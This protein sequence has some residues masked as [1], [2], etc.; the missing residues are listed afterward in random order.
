MNNSEIYRYW[1]FTQISKIVIKMSIVIILASVIYSYY[2]HSLAK[3]WRVIFTFLEAKIVRLFTSKND[4]IYALNNLLMERVLL[5]FQHIYYESLKL[6]G[7]LHLLIFGSMLFCLWLSRKIIN[8]NP[9]PKPLEPKINLEAKI[10]EPTN[11]PKPIITEE[12]DQFIKIP[13]I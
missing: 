11:K 6:A 8:E 9:Y 3:E 1:I 2:H 10:S 5:K 7:I 4:V 13:N 12:P